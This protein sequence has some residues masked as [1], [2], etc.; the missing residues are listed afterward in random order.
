MSKAEDIKTMQSD[1]KMSKASWLE[2][3]ARSANVHRSFD[4][5]SD[6]HSV[7]RFSDTGS[8]D[9]VGNQGWRKN[10][11]VSVNS[12]SRN[13][14]KFWVEKMMPQDMAVRNSLLVCIDDIDSIL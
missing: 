12:L 3:Q 13:L 9:S 5:D 1:T 14:G 8:W 6:V 4:Q 11:L 2:G 7:R 10:L